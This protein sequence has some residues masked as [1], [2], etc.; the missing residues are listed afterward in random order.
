MIY[1]L[2]LKLGVRGCTCLLDYVYEL[3]AKAFNSI[4]TLSDTFTAAVPG[5]FYR[6]HRLH[7]DQNRLAGTHTMQ[8]HRY[9]HL[10]GTLGTTRSQAQ[11][12]HFL[13]AESFLSMKCCFKI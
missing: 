2:C 13:L 9:T 11:S 6:Q 4:V 5:P 7:I 1:Q 3:D 8:S 10:Q 12:N